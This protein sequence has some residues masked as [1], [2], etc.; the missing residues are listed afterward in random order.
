[1]IVLRFAVVVACSAAL[2]YTGRPFMREVWPNRDNDS[3]G[4]VMSLLVLG[5]FVL[6]IL[7]ALEPVMVGRLCGNRRRGVCNIVRRRHDQAPEGARP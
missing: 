3:G 6:L 7:G 5:V 4:V 1:M 2:I